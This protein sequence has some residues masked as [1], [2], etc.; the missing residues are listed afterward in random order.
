MNKLYRTLFLGSY[1]PSCIL[2]IYYFT[3]YYL[4]YFIM[5]GICFGLSIIV[6]L[7]RPILKKS[8]RY[9]S[10]LK[11]VAELGMIVSFILRSTYNNEMFTFIMFGCICV[12]LDQLPSMLQSNV[13]KP[14]VYV[15]LMVLFLSQANII[16][17]VAGA[18]SCFLVIYEPVTKKIDT[19]NME[20][21]LKHHF[22]IKLLQVY[23]FFII[24]WTLTRLNEWALLFI[25][26]GSI[27]FNVYA[28]MSLDHK[29]QDIQTY[30][31]VNSL[32]PLYPIPL[33]VNEACH[34]CSIAKD[35]FKDHDL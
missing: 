12:L 25:L 3:R 6:V 24:E 13:E 28:Y 11:R 33:N 9:W 34:H 17:Q 22:N 32:P 21:S 27:L 30:A 15:T 26:T 5:S 14:A 35:V 31:N 19:D 7:H 16:A 29:V 23:M 8:V 10:M 20:V 4:T 18:C 2:L 1:I